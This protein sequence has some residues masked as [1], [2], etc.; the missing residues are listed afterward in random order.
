M[1]RGKTAKTR[2]K[3]KPKKSSGAVEA[4]KI[5]KRNKEKYNKNKVRN[6]ARKAAARA[7]VVEELGRRKAIESGKGE[8][9]DGMTMDV[10]LQAPVGE[11]MT[12]VIATDGEVATKGTNGSDEKQRSFYDFLKETDRDLADID[13][14]ELAEDQD[15]LAE[16]SREGGLR[17][18]ILAKWEQQLREKSLRTLKNTLIALKSVAPSTGKNSQEDVGNI[19]PTDPTGRPSR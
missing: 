4:P 8:L 5:Q 10:F 6:D 15:Y 9:F 11:P 2:K 1:T 18:P 3:L 14:D 13:T 19:F 12:E 17:L 7:I 16:L